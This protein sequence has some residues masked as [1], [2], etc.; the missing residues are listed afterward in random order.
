MRKTNLDKWEIFHKGILAID[1]LFITDEMNHLGVPSTVYHINFGGTIKVL[2]QIGAHY[3]HRV[4]GKKVPLT[5]K[6]KKPKNMDI[7][8]IEERLVTAHEGFSGRNGYYK[9]DD[10]VLTLENKK[11]KYTINYNLSQILDKDNQFFTYDKKE[12]EALSVWLSKKDTAK[13][14]FNIAHAKDENYDYK[15]NGY[16]FIGWNP[17]GNF[18]YERCR[19]NDHQF[20]EVS[21]PD[22]EHTLSCPVCKL[23]W[24]LDSS[25]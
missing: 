4:D 22:G 2:T 14:L 6:G 21:T 19:S 20:Y 5:F 17:K 1:D 18:L 7:K 13:R 15:G 25:G 10:I 23:Y 8:F 3:S 16:M 9:I 12:A 11:E 24:K